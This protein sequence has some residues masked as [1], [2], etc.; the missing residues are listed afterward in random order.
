MGRKIHTVS[1]NFTGGIISPGYL[2][3]LL[4]IAAAAG[5]SAVRLG[6]R[7]QLLMDVPV[8]QFKQF[9]ADCR[10]QKISFHEPEV[11]PNITSSYPAAGIFITDSWLSEGFTK[12]CLTCLIIPLP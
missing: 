11:C 2:Q 3:E 10:Q 9:S 1:I 12:M 6:L 4:S 5:V 7:Q 8:Q